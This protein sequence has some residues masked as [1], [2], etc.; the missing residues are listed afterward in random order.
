MVQEDCLEIP[1]GPHANGLAGTNNCQSRVLRPKISMVKL[2]LVCRGRSRTEPLFQYFSV[3]VIV[4]LW[5]NGVV[6]LVFYRVC[7]HVFVRFVLLSSLSS[8]FHQTD[9]KSHLTW[10]NL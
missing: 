2:F 3:N 8:W 9:T 1:N 5:S 10:D 7:L 6:L 4:D